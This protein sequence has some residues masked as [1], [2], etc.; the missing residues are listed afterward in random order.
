MK[1]Q[2]C[3]LFSLILPVL[4]VLALLSC[5]VAQGQ[6]LPGGSKFRDCEQC[7]EMTVIPAGTFMMGSP[8]A[9]DAHADEQ[10]QHEV[11]IANAFA[12]SR[13]EITFEQWNA[14]S[15]AGQCLQ[16]GEDGRG[17]DNYPVINVSWNDAQVYVAWLREITGEHYRL[18]SEAE[19]EYAT[20]AG[21]TT[22]WFWG[23]AGASGKACKFANLYD[24]A[25]KQAHPDFSW[26]VLDC[27]D[28][29]AQ[30]APVAQFQPNPFGLQDT[31][32]N[33]R[34]WVEDCYQNGYKGA[35]TDGSVR[36]PAP[37]PCE[38][39]FEGICMD[40]YENPDAADGTCEKRVVRGGAWSDGA[41]TARSAYRHAEA[42][43]TRNDRMG[44]RVARDLDRDLE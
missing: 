16:A 44:F 10:P 28:G 22:P 38:K 9:D 36:A 13:T 21:S 31:I 17:Q 8:P 25:G 14:C 30:S 15:A 12:V 42:G 33:V 29:Y 6:E 39:K 5:A 7:P 19:F 34:E 40:Q 4:V 1:T 35:P 20:R 37:R 43:D 32:G 27:N 2:N 26:P 41:A 23:D 18:L 24:E 11:S 3:A